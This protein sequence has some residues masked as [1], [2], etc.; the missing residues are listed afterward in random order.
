MHAMLGRN[1]WGDNSCGSRDGVMAQS[2]TRSQN[3]QCFRYPLDKNGAGCEWSNPV[4]QERIWPKEE[5]RVFERR[6]YKRHTCWPL[7]GRNNPF[8]IA[9]LCVSYQL[10]CSC[11]NISPYQ[12]DTRV[13]GVHQSIYRQLLICREDLTHI[14]LSLS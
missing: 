11:V 3:L 4:L 2:G 1:D 14:R 13:S 8:Y 5:N 12:R 7:T 6:K 9:F 10:F